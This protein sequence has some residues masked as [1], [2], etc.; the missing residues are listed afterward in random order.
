MQEDL[1]LAGRHLLPK[2]A[3]W[4]QLAQL[5]CPTHQYSR[6][7][8]PWAIHQPAGPNADVL[9][10]RPGPSCTRASAKRHTLGSQAVRKSG[11]H[12]GV[13]LSASP[14]LCGGSL[15]NHGP[16]GESQAQV[17]AVGS[18]SEEALPRLGSRRRESARAGREAL[19][20]VFLLQHRHGY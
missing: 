5:L 4:T 20:E 12:G 10:S 17:F 7:T 16:Q 19:S 13:A 14:S 6:K 15:R 9:L 11:H 3:F 18:R 1:L 8:L 2:E